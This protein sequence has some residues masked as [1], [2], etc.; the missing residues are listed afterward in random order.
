MGFETGLLIEP[1]WDMG[2]IIYLNSPGLMIKIAAAPFCTI[3]HTVL[4]G[5]VWAITFK[6]LGLYL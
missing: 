6:R 2:T 3:P 1:P 5:H 4:Y